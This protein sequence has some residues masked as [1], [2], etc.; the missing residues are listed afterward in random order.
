MVT[1]LVFIMAIHG[2]SEPD[3]NLEIREGQSS[4]PFEKRGGGGGGWTEAFSK[5]FFGPSGL[6]FA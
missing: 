1:L 3:P 4:K 5:T 2:Y 6:S